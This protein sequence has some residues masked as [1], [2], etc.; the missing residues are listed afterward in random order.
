ML[1]GLDGID[2]SLIQIQRL[3]GDKIFSSDIDCNTD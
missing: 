3:C 2:D 1:D